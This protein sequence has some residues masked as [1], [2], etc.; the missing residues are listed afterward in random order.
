MKK[1][2]VVTFLG[3]LLVGL[4]AFGF[5]NLINNNEKIEKTL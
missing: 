4:L 5:L 3:V 2:F 1:L